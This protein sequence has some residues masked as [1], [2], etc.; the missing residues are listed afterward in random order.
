MSGNELGYTSG[1]ELIAILRVLKDSGITHLDLSRNNL[2]QKTAEELV[3]ILSFLKEP[4]SITHLNLGW[5]SL[6]RKTG[7]ELVSILSFLKDSGITHLNLG[8]NDFGRKTEAELVAILGSLKESS[9]THLGLGWNGLRQKTAAE[10]TNIFQAIPENIAAVPLMLE[11]LQN[12]SSEQ[13]QAIQT[14]L[15]NVEQIISG[16]QNTANMNAY[17]RLGFMASA[18]SLLN[19]ASF[20]VAKNNTLFMLGIKETLP[21]ELIERINQFSG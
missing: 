10:L 3:S 15:P 1:E 12:M 18:P 5:N 4:S 17:I 6:A 21:Q 2:G 16:D 14:R 9:I 13:R 19:T 11:E 8:W 7:E 20:F